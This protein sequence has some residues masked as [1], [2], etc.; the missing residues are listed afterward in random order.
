LGRPVP[1]NDQMNGCHQNSKS[2]YLI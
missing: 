1:S 2:R